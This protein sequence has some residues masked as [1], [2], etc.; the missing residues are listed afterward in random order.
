MIVMMLLLLISGAIVNV[1]V[2]WGC[3]SLLDAS[4]LALCSPAEVRSALRNAKLN[5]EDHA[6]YDTFFVCREL[7]VSLRVIGRAS[8]AREKAWQLKEYRSGLPFRSLEG[9]V[10]G[11]ST[12]PSFARGLWANH[13]YA[14]VLPLR[15]IWPGFAINTIFY[16]AILWLLI[17]APGRIRRFMRLRQ[18]RCPAC[19]YQIAQGLSEV[20]SECGSPL[21]VG[22]VT[23]SGAA[24]DRSHLA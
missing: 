7:G 18:G 21:P 12:R 3:A 9:V 15:P 10:Y 19:G 23:K 20:C 1:A 24:T 22:I 8:E 11:S 17:F 2:A 13:K 6:D 14:V 16:A 4:L 5:P